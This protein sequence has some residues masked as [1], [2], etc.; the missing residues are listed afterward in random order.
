MKATAASAEGYLLWVGYYTQ[1][2][3]I[4]TYLILELSQGGKYCFPLSM[5]KETEAKELVRQS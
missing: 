2:F 1:C 3:L 5:V 4:I